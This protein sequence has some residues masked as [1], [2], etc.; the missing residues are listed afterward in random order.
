M[1][2]LLWSWEVPGGFPTGREKVYRVR[3]GARAHVSRRPPGPPAKGYSAGRTYFAAIAF[4]VSE[5]GPGCG[6]KTASR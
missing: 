4:A 6:T 3:E 2:G 1:T 5:S